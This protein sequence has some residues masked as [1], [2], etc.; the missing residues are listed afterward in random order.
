VFSQTIESLL[1]VPLTRYPI[2]PRSYQLRTMR[3]SF[4]VLWGLDGRYIIYKILRGGIVANGCE[5]PE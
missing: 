2:D 4:T 3:V 5:N 1:Q